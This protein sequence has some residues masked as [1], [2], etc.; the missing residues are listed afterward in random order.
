[1]YFDLEQAPTFFPPSC[2]ITLSFFFFIFS[3]FSFLFSQIISTCQISSSS[4]AFRGWSGALYPPRDSTLSTADAP[5][6]HRWQL[7][8]FERVQSNWI[9][10]WQSIW[11]ANKKQVDRTKLVQDEDLTANT[12]NWVELKHSVIQWYC[13]SCKR[14]PA[15]FWAEK[16]RQHNDYLASGIQSALD[17]GFKTMEPS[18]C[19]CS[20]THLLMKYWNAICFLTEP[21]RWGK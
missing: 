14:V 5:F 9:Y 15:E 10:F 17:F 3:H 11:R 2:T 18:L 7:L 1:M 16:Q 4:S 6:S 21:H 19:H 13:Y 8:L 20:H 12:A